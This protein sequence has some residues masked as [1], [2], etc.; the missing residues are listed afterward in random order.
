MKIA[1][2]TRFLLSKGL[3]GI[4]RVTFELMKRLVQQHPEDRFFFLFDR[5]S[6]ARFVFAENVEPIVLPPPARHPLLWYCWFEWSVARKLNSLQV[7]VF[8]S[9]DGFLS[10]SASTPTLLLIH[11][12]AHVHY[13]RQ[14]PFLVRQ[15]YNYFIP[16]YLH[17]ADQIACVSK[18]V[19]SD[20][21]DQYAINP[22]RIDTVYNSCSHEFRA[23]STDVRAQIQWRY[24]GG[25]EYF[26][27]VGAVHPRK[28]LH[29]LIQAFDRF[30]TTS[31]ADY[32]FLIAGRFGWQTTD[33]RQ[34]YESAHHRADIH[35]LGFVPQEVLPRLMASAFTLVYVSEFEGFG[36]PLL[37]AMH[38]DVPVIT[39]NKSSLPEVAGDAALLVEPTDVS[40]IASAMKQLADD[41][42]LRAELIE[43]G[44]I[45]KKAFDWN[46]SANQLY[47]LLKKT[48]SGCR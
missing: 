20:I 47:D 11:D 9:P 23:V 25:K 34:A 44:R 38:C 32:Q 2:N 33:V 35:F 45:R 22:S 14:I 8:F 10:L 16:K 37:E 40:A 41:P 26:L 29:R 42:K 15:Y 17:R 5:P 27:Y 46:R 36:I 3:E 48:A 13:P 21:V 1:V 7:D 30:K 18:F 31:N 4:G 24:A 39:S 28:N 19:K 12:I 43:K 6:D